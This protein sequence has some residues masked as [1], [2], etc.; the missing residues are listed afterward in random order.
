MKSNMTGNMNTRDLLNTQSETL[1]AIAKKKKK[2]K[3]EEEVPFSSMK[4]TKQIKLRHEGLLHEIAK[5]IELNKKF[6]DNVITEPERQ[7]NQESIRY[8]KKEHL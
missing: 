4:I 8:Y 2:E 3:E 5:E 6:I 7:E 1:T